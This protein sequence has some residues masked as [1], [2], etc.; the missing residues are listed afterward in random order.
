MV[1]QDSLT[2]A[3]IEELVSL[4]V[5]AL[6]LFGSR[7]LGKETEI[8]DYDY[9]ILMRDKGYRRGDELYERLYEILSSIS[10]RT[11]K[12]DVIDIV[13][14]RDIGLEL[15]FHVVRYGKI[16]F[17]ASPL[18]RVRFEERIVTLYCD[19]RPVL[20]RFDKAILESL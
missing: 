19:Y 6:Y 18:E 9:A 16:L 17:E 7:A 15:Q 11:H 13:F 5:Q 20:D 3:Q 2:D 10:P 8:S 4:G 14:L 1:Y 12:N